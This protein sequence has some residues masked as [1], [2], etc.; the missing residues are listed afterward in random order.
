M[1]LPGVLL[2][3]QSYQIAT[4]STDSTLRKRTILSS[5]SYVYDSIV[6]KNRSR[7]SC[8][9]DFCDPFEQPVVNRLNNRISSRDWLY[10]IKSLPKSTVLKEIRNPVLSVTA[11]ASVISIAH[12]LM[13]KSTVP[14]FNTV[15][16]YMH[17]GLGIHSFLVSSIGLLLVFRT[18]S[19]YQRFVV[20]S[21]SCNSIVISSFIDRCCGLTIM[22]ILFSKQ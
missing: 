19:A 1:K 2:L 22:S 14:L 13:L 21:I 12:R 5:D 11:W 17:I 4:F 7:N 20:S 10:N 18:N 8:E 3:L 15:S 9:S 6:D 16:S